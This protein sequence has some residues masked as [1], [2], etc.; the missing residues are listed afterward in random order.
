[1]HPASYTVSGVISYKSEP[2]GNRNT[3]YRM[4][5]VPESGARFY[6]RDSFVKGI[7]CDVEQPLS[8]ITDFSNRKGAAG[9][10]EIAVYGGAGVD[11]DYIAFLEYPCPGR[12]SMNDLIVY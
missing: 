10:T 5:D 11:T 8:L 4:T 7:K 2:G 12:D 6:R 9:I 1:M 3:F